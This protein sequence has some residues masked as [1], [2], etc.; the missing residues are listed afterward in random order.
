M[1]KFQTKLKELWEKV[2][3]FFKKLNKKMRILLGVCLVVVLAAAVL[4]ALRMNKKEYA[5]LYTGLTASDTSTVINFLSENGVTDYKIQGD[6]IL[7]PAGREQQL[8]MLLA[9]SGSLNSG[10]LYEFYTSRMGALTTS[11]EEERLWLASIE[12]KLASTIKLFDGVRDATV[13]I[14]PGTERIYMLQD[15]VNPSKAAV[16]ITPDGNRQLDDNVIRAIRNIVAH[17][18]EELNIEN[19]SIEDIY[20]HTYSDNSSISQSNQA[21]ALKLEYEERI[22]NNVRQQVF[23][24][25]SSIYGE[26]NVNVSVLCSVEVA[27]KI[28]DKTSYEQPV[29]SVDGG[30]LITKDTLF[31]EVIRDGSDAAGGTVGTGTNS[32][33][34][35]YPNLEDE[36][37]GNNPY[38]GQQIDREGVVD[39]TKEQME[40]LEGRM[41]D[42]RVIV[43]VNQNCENSGAMTL[44]ALRDKVATL[45]GIGTT[46]DVATSRVHVSIAP[47]AV[48]TPAQDGPGGIFLE[49]S[50][51]LYAAI[52]G[53]VLFLL[54]LVLVILLAR[55]S[56]KRKL[57]RQ[58]A[59]EEEML[60][61]EAAAEAAAVIAAAPPTG[62][63]DIMEVNTEKSME[64]RKTVRQFAQNNPEIAAQMVKAWLKGE[65]TSG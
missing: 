27:R 42:L 7:V 28:V 10:F 21:T 35:T 65:D 3:G 31:W 49:N 50:W 15:G 56:R 19:V 12:Q 40:V 41:S 16:T 51:V 34:P 6:S 63:A 59:L 23:N 52:G 33:L 30:G 11:V 8:Q 57:A 5:V 26:G 32:Q 43:T 44:D 13:S 60:A 48:N 18:V 62:G 39:I 17:S 58:Q 25:L 53:L 38:A 4:L 45:A 46:T 54:L 37:D 64:L 47:F 1:Q 61:A 2:K 22:S 9:T 20:G 24:D 36:M 55:R 29:G 14:T